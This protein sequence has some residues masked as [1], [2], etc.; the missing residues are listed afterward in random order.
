MTTDDMVLPIKSTGKKFTIG[1]FFDIRVNS[2]G[3][4]Q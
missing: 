2:K 1:S 3:K 4:Y